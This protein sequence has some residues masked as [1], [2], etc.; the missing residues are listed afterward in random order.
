MT[1][2]GSN[3]CIAVALAFAVMATS[4]CDEQSSPQAPAPVIGPNGL[5][6]GNWTSTITTP[7]GQ[8]SICTPGGGGT[9]PTLWGG[10]F[11]AGACE[12]IRLQRA[13]TD[14]YIFRQT[15][16]TGRG[17]VIATGRAWGDLTSSYRAEVTVTPP[18]APNAPVRSTVVARRV[19]HC[20]DAGR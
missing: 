7:D 5:A 15:C 19:D 4:A 1:R 6:G 3:R 11:A 2:S 17:D 12:P 10:D 8:S 13:A 14:E 16:R 20:P 9:E 18:G